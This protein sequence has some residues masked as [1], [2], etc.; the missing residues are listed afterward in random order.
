MVKAA[1]RVYSETEKPNKKRLMKRID[2]NYDTVF[3]FDTET[4]IDEYQNLKFGSFVV[5][6]KGAI[7]SIGLFCNPKFVSKK[8]RSELIKYCKKNP[9]IRLYGLDEFIEVFYSYIYEKRVPCIGFNLPFDLSRLA[10]DFGYA[11]GSMK[12]GFVFKLS[13]QR[14]NPPII[15][16]H[17]DSSQSF[18]RFQSTSYDRFSGIFLDLKTLAVTLTDDKHITLDKAAQLFNKKH[19]KLHVEEH[20]KITQEYIVYNLEDTLTTAELYW[21]LKEE[22]E[23]YDIPIPLSRVYSSASLGKAWLDQIGIRPFME[24]NSDFPKEV[25]GYLMS[26]YY[27]GRAEVKIRKTP[28]RVTVLD[29]LSM[30]PTM[31]NITGLYNFLIAQ[32]IDTVDDTQNVRDLIEKISLEDLRNPD[33]LKSLNVL[34]EILPDGDILPVRTKYNDAEESLNVGINH[35]TSQK[36]MWYSLPDVVASKILSSKTPR[37]LRA[38]R[39]VPKGRQKL[40]KVNTLGIE[41]DPNKDNIFKILIEKRQELKA[42]GD[43]RQKPIKILA[44]ASSYGIYIEM[45]P[46][47]IG[48]D[49]KTNIYSNKHFST[50]KSMIE[51]VGRYFNPIISVLITGY[52]RLMLAIA[53]AL[54]K[55]TDNVHAFCDTDSMAVPKECVKEMQDFFQPLNPY[56]FDKPLFKEEKKDVWFYGISAKRYVLYI[57]EGNKIMI[58]D[59]DER[60]YSLHGLGHLLNPFGKGVNWHKQVWEDILKLH[61][62]IM[63]QSEFIQK[64]SGFYAI[65]KLSMS[66]KDLMNRFKTF[67]KGKPYDRLIKP[68]NFFLIGVGNNKD[69]KPITPFSKEPQ[70]AVHKPFIDYKSGNVMIGIEYWKRLSDVL[71]SYID[72]KESKFEGDL[73]I[74]ERKHLNISDFTYIG[75]EASNLDRTGTLDNPKYRTYQDQDSLSERISAMSFEE[76]KE[77]GIPKMTYYRL[78]K[79]LKEGK[80]VIL[81]DKTKNKLI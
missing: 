22:Q 48:E 80:K 63:N 36:P 59:G 21:R 30:Y 40:N 47:D 78:R 34:I 31:F 67:N 62:G 38:I 5:S 76:A 39:F 69:I 17:N 68:F 12:G 10:Y 72:H 45:N 79:T 37:I 6:N 55:R 1:V 15:V 26:A 65:S 23:K 8:E 81:R 58:K 35:I 27:G 61:Y 75:K 24:L 18:I 3:V 57:K 74:L 71:L 56:D 46:K 28:T 33:I 52:A 14:K 25:L 2:C 42:K 32:R 43:Y 60:A 77:L 4:T 44:N 13:E 66:S 73:G 7:I 70:E 49:T 16:K 51:E 19:K 9:A 41:I 53:E 54:L 20:G 64:Y 50:D 29:F 11:R